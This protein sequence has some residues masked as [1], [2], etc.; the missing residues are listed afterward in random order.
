MNW[1]LYKQLPKFYT[2]KPTF[3]PPS[4]N[5]CWTYSRLAK[6]SS[7]FAFPRISTSP[8]QYLSSSKSSWL[9]NHKAY[10]RMRYP[11]SMMLSFCWNVGPDAARL[12]SIDEWIRLCVLDISYDGCAVCTKYTIERREHGPRCWGGLPRERWVYTVHLS[13]RSH[14]N[15]MQGPHK[16]GPLTLVIPVRPAAFS[17]LKKRIK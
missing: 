2:R 14:E 17:S 10:S 6:N 9:W 11:G 13:V 4:K 8:W 5:Q 15:G 1:N 3:L 12:F 16:T 7:L